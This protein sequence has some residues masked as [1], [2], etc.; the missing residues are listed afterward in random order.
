MNFN[1]AVVFAAIATHFT[2]KGKQMCIFVQVLKQSLLIVYD[3]IFTPPPPQSRL[4]PL[5]KTLYLIK[6]LLLLDN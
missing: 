6:I 3:T 4:M 5:P 1:A 2:K